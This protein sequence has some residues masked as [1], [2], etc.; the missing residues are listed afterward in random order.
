MKSFYSGLSRRK[1]FWAL[2]VLV[3]LISSFFA[4]KYY[5]VAFPVV[6]L[7][8]QMDRTT[9]LSR[10]AQLAKNNHWGPESF[11]QAVS[12]DQDQ[13]PQ[14]FIELTAGGSAAFAQVLKQERFSPY[15]WKVRHY[16]QG[17]VHEAMIWFTPKGDLYGFLNAL[18]ENDPG[19]AL[20]SEKARVLAE[21][22]ARQL[23]VRLLEFELV[24]RSQEVKPNQ[25]VD[26]TFVYERP[27]ERIGEGRY[28]L[29]L[30]VAGDQ[31]VRLKHWVQVPDAF[32]RRY[33]EMR[34]FNN[35][36]ASI[37]STVILLAYFLGA[38]GVGLFLLAKAGQVIWKPAA[39]AGAI[40]AGFQVLE[41]FNHLP[42]IWMS[43]DTALPASGFLLRQAVSAL[44]LFFMEWFM[45]TL[46]FAAAEGLSRRAFPHHP[47]F[48]R[49]WSSG[50]AGTLSVLGR[51]L[52]GYLSVGLFFLFVVAV[53]LFGTR[54]LGWWVPSETLFHPDALATL[55]PWFTS[56]S[57]SLHAGFWEES[58]F[59]A[60]P[61]AGA[62]LLGDRFG[63]RKKWIAF[64]MVF[65]ALV[66]ASAHANYPAQPS[67]A[68]VLELILPSFFFGALYLTYGLLPGIVLHFTFDTVFFALPLFFAQT[69]GVIW[70]QVL[71]VFFALSPL[72]IS[73]VSRVRLG[74]WRYL[75]PHELNSN[76]PRNEP[77]PSGGHQDSTLIPGEE[78][79]GAS[80]IGVSP[81]KSK[82]LLRSLSPR[83]E[84][85]WIATAGVCFLFCSFGLRSENLSPPLLISRS[86][87]I[88][89]AQSALIQ[90]GVQLSPSWESAAG[91]SAQLDLEDQFVWKTAGKAT[92]QKLLGS[93]LMPPAWMVRFFRFDQ[94]VT[95]RANEF[96]V[97]VIGSGDVFTIRHDL[98]EE[99]SLPEITEEQAKA[100]ALQA[101]GDQ[102][103]ALSL[104]LEFQSSQSF[105]LPH[106][107]DWTLIFT[108]RS[109]VLPQGAARVAVR[110]SGNE[111]TSVRPFVFIPEQWLRA[112]RSRQNQMGIIQMVSGLILL[113]GGIGAM[114]LALRAWLK[115]P[116]LSR[117]FQL[118]FWLL[119]GIE[120]VLL[121]SSI[122][123]QRAQLLTEEPALNQWLGFFSMGGVKALVFSGVLSLLLSWIAQQ[124]RVLPRFQ[125]AQ[126]ARLGYS[127]G[128]LGAA[129]VGLGLRRLPETHPLMAKLDALREAIPGL[130][131]LQIFEQFLISSVLLSLLGMTLHWV[132]HAWSTRRV[133][134]L[135]VSLLLSLLVMSFQADDLLHWGLGGALLGLVQ[136][137]MFATV[138]RSSLGLVPY[139][140]AG[141]FAL[142]GVKQM[143]LQGYPSVLGV[144]LLGMCLILGFLKAR[145]RLSKRFES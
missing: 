3:F 79:Q 101:I 90:K 39:I 95:E 55:C 94:E 41:Q 45:L 52:G 14:T 31:L 62:A 108:D 86:Q 88:A 80:P 131:S 73:L 36:I 136:Y 60:V 107:R 18:G 8:I 6:D 133:Q 20:S 44:G 48:W 83:S 135:G 137:G 2:Q 116:C 144:E 115:T 128:I 67:Y 98:P 87:A 22:R 7:K 110:I 114:S 120:W 16:Q 17:D 99:D 57:N 93:F 72:W 70:D 111:V 26:H 43:Y 74:K 106:R 65:Q 119:F 122:P 23:G 1:G 105:K 89:R 75:S 42:L 109:V 126:T 71:V 69:P 40:L 29:K 130:F 127:L 134:T 97:A 54:T 132:S 51:T 102:F 103:P 96:Q 10:A 50:N 37:S 53:Y 66:F 82:A 140:C 139:A 68:R 91:V 123:A 61:L 25:R 56:L 125:P 9:A 21:Q 124:E 13:Q 112:E 27:Q 104:N 4:V 47:Q 59:R 143:T 30:V 117:G 84:K 33:A 77:Q 121:L 129:G 78:A 63:G 141:V 85:G 34:S 5:S 12:F 11:R 46:S 38:C 49:L 142:H 32:E 35:T 58:L 19:P 64:A 81:L 145:E 76:A 118:H 24:E 15:T 100:K 138:I 28:R 92:Y 113:V